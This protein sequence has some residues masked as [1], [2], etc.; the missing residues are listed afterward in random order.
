MK[1]Y[2]KASDQQDKKKKKNKNKKK[3]NERTTNALGVS[4]SQQRRRSLL[5]FLADQSSTVVVFPDQATFPRV[6]LL[7]FLDAHW[8]LVLSSQD[9]SQWK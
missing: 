2:Q 1:A 9:T 5:P 4:P 8:C 6:I 7:E 3:T